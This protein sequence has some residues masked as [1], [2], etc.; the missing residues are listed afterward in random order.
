M[1][2]VLYVYRITGVNNVD[3]TEEFLY[4]YFYIM[5][6]T[7]PFARTGFPSCIRNYIKDNIF[8][9]AL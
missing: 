4:P 2:I 9:F 1:Y 8:I 6:Y 7:K 3:L 5:S